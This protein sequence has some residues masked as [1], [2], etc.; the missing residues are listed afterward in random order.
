L[1]TTVEDGHRRRR[2]DV[3]AIEGNTGDK[4]TN[5]FVRPSQ[6]GVYLAFFSFDEN[7]LHTIAMPVDRIDSSIPSS[8]TITD[9]SSGAK[10]V[11]A[12]KEITQDIPSSGSSLVEVSWK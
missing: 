5:V 7:Q 2:E 4:A 1:S 6:H 3:P 9:L 8:V 11:S 12:K 10:M